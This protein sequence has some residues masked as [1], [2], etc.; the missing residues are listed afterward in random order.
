MIGK[1][2]RNFHA[3]LLF[4]VVSLVARPTLYGA[5]FESPDSVFGFEPDS[6]AII[7]FVNHDLTLDI[8]RNIVSGILFG[9]D[10][11]SSGRGICGR[12]NI[13]HIALLYPGMD[14]ILA[15][16]TNEFR[17]FYPAAS[18]EL[19]TIN[20]FPPER[21]PARVA[22]FTSGEFFDDPLPGPFGLERSSKLTYVFIAYVHTP[23][24][25][26]ILCP[27]PGWTNLPQSPFRNSSATSEAS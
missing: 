26:S 22:A 24:Q 6:H 7:R 10:Y 2:F 8:P 17:L 15:D 21:E 20:I 13:P 9:P 18:P 23:E 4:S 27:R 5:N 11:C 16:R 1:R 25:L 14:P 12:I 19:I 3:I